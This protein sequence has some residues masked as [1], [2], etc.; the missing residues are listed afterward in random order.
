MRSIR[1]VVFLILSLLFIVLMVSYAGASTPGRFD[2]D[3]IIVIDNSGSMRQADPDMLALTAA[4]LFID[5]NAGSDSRIGYVMYTQAIV[6]RRDLTELVSFR[7]DI[8]NEISATRWDPRGWTDIALGIE[9]ALEMFANESDRSRM[10]MIILLSDGNTELEVPAHINPRPIRTTAESNAALEVAITDAANMGIPIYTIGFNFDGELDMP[11]M[12]RI[13]ATT[14]GIMR[15]TNVASNLPAIMGE[16]YS[17]ITGARSSSHRIIGTGYPQS[18]VISVE[19]NSIHSAMVTIISGRPIRDISFT[20]PRG[21]EY[22]GYDVNTDASGVY[23]LL[24]LTN[25]SMGD[26]TLTFTGSSGDIIF[27]DLLSIYDMEFVFDLPRT[28]PRPMG[29]DY[30]E[31]EFSWRLE[32]ESGATVTDTDL[33]NKLEPRLFLRS[34]DTDT[35]QTINLNP[36][37][38]SRVMHL[39]PGDYSAYMTLDSGGII[40]TSHTH[41]F[42][43]PEPPPEPGIAPISFIPGQLGRDDTYN[44]SMMTIFSASATIDLHDFIHVPVHNSIISITAG[45]GDW[46]DYIEWNYDSFRERIDL[47]AINAGSTEIRVT[48]TD[49]L[50]PETNLHF[51]IDIN[52]SSG[53]LPIIIAA[54]ILLLIIIIIIA[55]IQAKKP[56]I[57]DPM[58]K[59]Y[60]KMSLP[61]N[62]DTE[63]PPEYALALPAI[64]GKKSLREIIN[65]NMSISEPYRAAFAPISWFADR[66]VI[67]AKS[68]SL[69]EIKIPSNAGCT[70]KVDKQTGKNSVVF[71]RDGGAEIRIGSTSSGYDEYDEFV[72]EFGSPN[73]GG[74]NASMDFSDGFNIRNSQS[75]VKID[76]DNFWN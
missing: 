3:V 25:P 1:K 67:S 37:E 2:L 7:R 17:H 62:L 60:I 61:S 46:F 20:D 10:P 43:V 47:S 49:D 42:T 75:T 74:N 72:I 16:I 52:I 24:T 57:N 55:A 51:T 27:I 34:A 11:T 14:G 30:S 15:E 76:D 40:R 70:V 8:K 22:D 65:M 9:T 41:T 53:W 28:T 59:L 58:S 54:A 13:A 32:D 48:V 45:R 73:K 63:V 69:L 71:G 5:M 50:D 29:A 66:A 23:T 68:K 38:T 26:W 31:A 33:I 39:I 44:V 6:G 19:N 4:N 36:G 64:K 56:K 18:V 12:D 35:E 21:A